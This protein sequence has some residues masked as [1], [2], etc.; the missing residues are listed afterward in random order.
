MD[1]KAVRLKRQKGQVDFSEAATLVTCLADKV[2][3]F[4]KGNVPF[5]SNTQFMSKI[6]LALHCPVANKAL[7]GLENVDGVCFVLP[8]FTD[9]QV[10]S[11]FSILVSGQS[12]YLSIADCSKIK[13]LCQLLGVTNISINGSDSPSES[14]V[15]NCS[16]QPKEEASKSGTNQLFDEFDFSQYFDSADKVLERSA[17]HDSKQTSIE[18][19]PTPPRPIFSGDNHLESR[20]K[21]V[22][23]LLSD[24]ALASKEPDNRV[25]TPSA[26]EQYSQCNINQKTYAKSS[27]GHHGYG[28]DKSVSGPEKSVETLSDCIEPTYCPCCYDPVDFLDYDHMKQHVLDSLDA[29]KV[30]ELDYQRPFPFPANY[31]QQKFVQVEEGQISCQ[32]CGKSESSPDKLFQHYVNH[33]SHDIGF[34]DVCSENVCQSTERELF[35]KHLRCHGNM[36]FFCGCCEFTVL[37]DLIEHTSVHV[38]QWVEG[39]RKANCGPKRCSFCGCSFEDEVHLHNHLKVHAMNAF[40]MNKFCNGC[41]KNHKSM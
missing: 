12:P 22:R 27:N 40:H 36:C 14:R 7:Q 26:E 33:L 8:D 28:P 15:L 17:Q 5:T 1:D 16:D 30:K 34:C 2:S 23:I 41:S 18:L 10:A 29:A 3:I 37:A 32:V 39:S 24:Q 4:C 19:S 20:D 11:L 25:L 38:S 6:F 9:N 21:T 31:N 13:E 35:F